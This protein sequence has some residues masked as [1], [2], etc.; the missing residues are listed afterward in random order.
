MKRLLFFLML[1]TIGLTSCTENTRARAFGGKQTIKLQP[2]EWLINITWK[3]A[4]L[5]L[6]TQDTTTGAL[7]FRE[8]SSWGLM[9]GQITIEQADIDSPPESTPPPVY[10]G[11]TLWLDTNT[12]LK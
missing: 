5:W 10:S 9:E 7:Y 1:L 2:N 3:E 4:D 12:Q 11:D 6:L 8:N